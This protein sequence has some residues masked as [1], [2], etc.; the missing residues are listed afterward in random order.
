[1][2][3][4]GGDIINLRLGFDTRLW[5]VTATVRTR[6]IGVVQIVLAFDLG[7]MKLRIIISAVI[8]PL[9]KLSKAF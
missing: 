9:P 8:Q 1:L 6:V 3:A 5:N 7:N 4:L 2:E